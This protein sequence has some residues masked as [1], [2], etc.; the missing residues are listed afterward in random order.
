MKRAARLRARVERYGTEI[1]SSP[2]MQNEKKYMQHGRVSVYEHSFDVASKCLAIA[3]RFHIKA[4]RR[5]LV[6]GA[7]LHDYFLYDW[8]EKGNAH[9][10]H[11]FTHPKCALRN[12]ER[13]FRLSKKERDMIRCHMFPLTL[14]LPRYRESVILCVADKLCALEETFFR[15]G[16]K[17]TEKC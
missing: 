10:L 15:R 6:R 8:H 2:G 13:D 1:L 5:A 16:K 3:E 11:G 12:A 7:L 17:E 4:D 9:R 14:T